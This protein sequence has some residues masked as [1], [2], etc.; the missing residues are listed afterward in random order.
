MKTKYESWRITDLFRM[1]L[2]F[3]RMHIGLYLI[4]IALL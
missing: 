4:Y 2:I 1:L 3:V